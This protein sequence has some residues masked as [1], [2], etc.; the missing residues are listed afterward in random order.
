[1]DKKQIPPIGSIIE[2]EGHTYSVSDEIPNNMDLVI[3]EYGVWV[4]KDETGFGSAPLPYW[5]N[6]KTCKKLIKIS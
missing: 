2:H 5:A 3:T 1:M 4:F 6:K